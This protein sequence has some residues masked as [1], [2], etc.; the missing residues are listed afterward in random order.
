MI[1]LIASDIDGTLLAEGTM[2]LDKEVFEIIRELK[3]KGILFVA[4]SGR[5]IESLE[6][7]F[8]PVIEDIYF[9]AEN[10]SCVK[11]QGREL[12]NVIL[13]RDAAEDFVRSAR[14]IPD[15]TIC[16]TRKNMLFIEGENE[17][18][19]HHLVD[20]YDNNVD[21]IDDVLKIPEDFIKISL[22]KENA[23]QEIAEPLIEKWKDRMHVMVAGTSWLDC[24][25][26]DADKGKALKLI[27]ERLDVRFEETMAF[28]D[29]H[30]D[31]GMLLQ[32][33]ESYAVENAKQEVKKVS[34]YITK[35][36]EE[37]GVIEI[38]R[39]IC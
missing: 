39:T 18:L 16:A 2:G 17:K 4:A 33:K 5:S 24:V 20:G 12:H 23:I 25:G 38:L 37:N 8:A 27:Q 26:M 3:D 11:Y 9:I 22:Y 31:V 10:G 35:S 1:K 34:K 6:S 15:T 36:N 28:G 29:N 19:Y 13:D 30:N 21:Y 7:L 32:A 14:N